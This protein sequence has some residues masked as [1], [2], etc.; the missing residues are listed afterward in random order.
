MDFKEMCENFVLER[1]NFYIEEK[2]NVKKDIVNKYKNKVGNG[3]NLKELKIINEMFLDFKLLSNTIKRIKEFY[4]K[5]KHYMDSY[6]G[7]DEFFNINTFTITELILHDRLRNSIEDLD[8]YSDSFD[9]A[10]QDKLYDMHWNRFISDLLN[11]SI[12]YS[13][14]NKLS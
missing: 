14:K 3:L 8:K 2:E 12:E 6:E 7:L 5:D 11:F 10:I 9:K 1:L 13:E 4:E